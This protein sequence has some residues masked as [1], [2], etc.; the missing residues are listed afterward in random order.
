MPAGIFNSRFAVERI[1]PLPLHLLHGLV[2]ISPRPPQRLHTRVLEMTPNGVRW[3]VLTLPRPLHS[4][5]TCFF[6]L[7]SAPVPWHCGQASMCAKLMVFFT[8][9][10]ASIKLIRTLL[11]ISPPRLG[12][13]AFAAALL[14]P[15]PPKPP[16]P[17]K[18]LSKISP[19]SPKPPKSPAPPPA[20][21]KFGSTPAC[22][23]WSYLARLSAS[24]KTPYASLTSLNFASASLS[25]GWRSGWYFLAMV[26]KAFL[27]SSS[28]APFCNPST[29]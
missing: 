19:M 26:L 4:G 18:M 13:F 2:T 10:Q 14:P 8:P 1:R 3:L 25:P 29:S 12:A 22:P 21:A 28:V 17:P 15:P 24:D 7:L 20:P 5:Q 23:N 11:W 27:I 9:W 16:N 6:V